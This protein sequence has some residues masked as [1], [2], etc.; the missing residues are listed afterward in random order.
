VGGQVVPAGSYSLF[1]IPTRAGATLILN[2]E[3]MR[4][5]QPLAGTE[6][7]SSRDLARIP[8]RSRTLAAPVESLTIEVVPAGSNAG[9]LRIAW[10]T[11]E[12]T[13]PVRV[14]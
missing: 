1:T 14:R 10:D 8:M 4:D 3:T 5:G 7:D 9:T 11:R 13:V 12:M 2:R 6:Y